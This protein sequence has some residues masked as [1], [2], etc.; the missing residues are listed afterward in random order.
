MNMMLE[1]PPALQTRMRDGVPLLLDLLSGQAFEVRDAEL[2][3]IIATL[4]DLVPDTAEGLAEGLA[5]EM[6]LDQESAS[7][8]V[9]AL[10]ELGLL[11]EASRVIAQ[12]AGVQAWVDNGW[13]DA[14]ILHFASRDIHYVDDPKE[15]G[16]DG[17]MDFEPLIAES[18]APVSSE[19]PYFTL[20][21]PDLSPEGSSI[22]NGIMSRRS[23]QPFN[24]ESLRLGEIENILWN[25]NLYARDRAAIN[26]RED[27]R[28]QVYDSAFSSLSSCLVAYEPIDLG[29]S[30]LSPGAYH[31]D[32]GSHS[33]LLL[34]EGNLRAEVSRIATGQR[35]ASK[36]LF[37]IVICADWEAYSRRYPHER[38][39]RNLL[40]N[41]AQLAQFYL[42][43]SSMVKLST[44]M[45]P[46]IHD[47]D[48]AEA[49]GVTRTMPMYLVTAG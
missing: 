13:M 49:I 27:D 39:Y 40:I 45:T 38:S 34:R 20:R 30:I 3:P 31:Y 21:R 16:G 24:R 7:A 43:L 11:T 15:L 4:V 44:F 37:S 48:M 8:A 25:A 47:E 14:L 32:V 6:Q 23:F 19:G 36:G 29:S 2:M 17:D 9:D 18:A 5:S 28:D 41:T 12:K 35:R 33:L 22:I 10:C 1:F 42:V 26:F 46:A